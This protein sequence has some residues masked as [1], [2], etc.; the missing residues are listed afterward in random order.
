[1]NKHLSKTM[2]GMGILS[3]AAVSAN[4]Q[5]VPLFETDPQFIALS[6]SENPGKWDTDMFRGNAIWA[7]VNNDGWM[8]LFQVGNT[9]AAGWHSHV[10]GWTNNAGTFTEITGLP[11][12]QRSDGP[13]CTTSDQRGTNNNTLAW[14]DYNND[15]NIDIIQ[16]GIKEGAAEENSTAAADLFINLYRG[17]GD[18][19]FTLV[20]NTGLE[21]IGLEQET[22]YSGITMVVDFD[23]D[24]YQDLTM[25]G[26]TDD[27][28]EVALY[29]NNGDGTFTKLDP[30]TTFVDWQEMPY[31]LALSSGSIA[32]GDYNNDGYPDFAVN[33]WSDTVG[34][35]AT[36]VCRNNG[37][38]SFL[39]LDMSLTDPYADF[40][41]E[42]PGTQKGMLMWGDF[43][44]DGW[45][46]LFV[47]GETY[48][49][50]NWGR[51]ADILLNR[52]NDYENLE[53]YPESQFQRIP[54]S[55]SGINLGAAKGN[56]T[57]VIDLDGNGY[58][59][60][61]VTGEGAGA[62]T[63]FIMNNGDLTFSEDNSTNANTDFRSGTAMEFF[64][65]DG[66][67]Y[68]DFFAMG[69][70]D[71]GRK[72]QLFKNTGKYEDE[73]FESHDL[74]KN[75]APQGPSSVAMAANGNA[76]TITWGNGSDNETP[77]EALRYNVAIEKTNG[78]I[79]MLVP[80]D[81]ETGDLKV[82]GL[83]NLILGNTYTINIPSSDI[84]QA[85][86][87]T[88]DGAKATSQFVEVGGSSAELVSANDA[89]K[90]WNNSDV[91]NVTV[92]DAATVTIYDITG[93]KVAAVNINGSTTIDCAGYN[94]LYLVKVE[95]ENA[96]KTTK[97]IF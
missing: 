62:M 22:L 21:V 85:Y 84:K 14:I 17:N 11:F 47:C 52:G 78:E 83:A 33:G 69:Y 7:D 61:V 9:T 10:Y 53:D 64:D 1:M 12:V 90:V 77:D 51:T 18:G 27:T 63:D 8:D 56:S 70:R 71:N 37:D 25:T 74:A 28:R 6:D 19:T 38:G 87:Q 20:E 57:D 93:N 81:L 46:D 43:N 15:G 65:Y 23:C 82:A 54:A 72:F 66:D 35:V 68:I 3:L 80:A 95:T 88:V 50:T 49:G 13:G 94:G 42:E 29:H 2:L 55:E 96:C 31:D 86:V 32:W 5:I 97:V 89:I 39:C 40:L 91:L 45:L 44:N 26:I 75:N 36:I 48:D 41:P 30:A 76:T 16:R 34:G 4:A 24:G 79:F 60:I 59:D 73:N 58:L 67:G 92:D